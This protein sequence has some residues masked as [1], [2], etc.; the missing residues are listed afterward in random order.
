MTD[1]RRKEIEHYFTIYA[2]NTIMGSLKELFMAGAEW[3][4]RTNPWKQELIKTCEENGYLQQC[5][6]NLKDDHKKM[7][8]NP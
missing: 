5:L 2:Q 6:Q 1:S 3:A 8:N 7:R 4:D